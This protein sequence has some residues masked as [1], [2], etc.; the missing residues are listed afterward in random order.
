MSL[1]DGKDEHQKLKWKRKIQIQRGCFD[2][3]VSVCCPKIVK[4]KAWSHFVWVPQFQ[5]HNT[6]TTKQSLD[7]PD[8]GGTK[9]LSS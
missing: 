4:R 6:N 1:V 5:I 8:I 2:S 3:L 9:Y 7:E